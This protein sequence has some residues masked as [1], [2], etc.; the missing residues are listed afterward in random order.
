MYTIQKKRLK[1]LSLTSLISAPHPLFAN[2]DAF[3]SSISL[4]C[5]SHSRSRISCHLN[6]A[7]ATSL[8]QEQT[9]VGAALFSNSSL[10][11]LCSRY[12]INLFAITSS[13]CPILP[14]VHFSP[15]QII[16]VCETLEENGDI[17][18]L[19]RFIWSLQ[20]SPTSSN[21]LF[22]HESILRARAI[23]AFHLGNY[24]E[25]YHLLENYKYKRDYH[26]KLQTIWIEAHYQEAEKLRGRSLEP[27]RI[28]FR[29]ILNIIIY[30]MLEGTRSLL[31][32]YYL[33]DPYPN[34]IKKRQLAQSINWINSN[35]SCY[36][37]KHRRQ[38]DRAAQAK[39]RQLYNLPIHSH[40]YSSSSIT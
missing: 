22:E 8:L 19:G 7:K 30:L 4:K 35:T 11:Y 9:T 33:E 21:I 34:P 17:N 36:W 24:Q 20:L 12:S 37:C 38:R 25:L 2:V 27:V 23:V 13:S 14:K 10:D 40:S 29:D 1:T 26:T 28:E 39:H 3:S 18:R 32:E 6:Y 31:R 15:E 5:C 16:R